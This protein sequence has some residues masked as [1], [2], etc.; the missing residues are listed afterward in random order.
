MIYYACS[1]VPLEIL[2][3]SGLSFMKIERA[4]YSEDP[5]VHRNLCGYCKATFEAVKDMNSDDLF[6]A[7]DSCDAMRRIND[8][9]Q[10]Y[11][12]AQILQLRLPWKR[13]DAS[14]IFYRNQLEGLVDM[15]SL[16]RGKTITIRELKEGIKSFNDLKKHLWSLHNK[17]IAYTEI[18]KAIDLANSGQKYQPLDKKV[19]KN[20]PRLAVAG[21]LMKDEEFLKMVGSIGAEIVFNETCAGMRGFTGESFPTA[22]PIDEIATRLI[23]RRIPCGRFI[24]GSDTSILRKIFQSLKVDGVLRLNQ[25]FCD[26]F[27]DY[28][29]PEELPSLSLEIDYPLASLGQL[30]TRIGAFVE[31]IKKGISRVSVSKTAGRY[32][33]GVDSGS[34]TTN[35]VITNDKGEILLWKIAPTGINGS[36]TAS[37][38][39]KEAQREMNF[40]DDDIAYCVATGYGRSIVDFANETITEITCHARGAKRFFPEAK[41]IIDIGGQD[42]KAI[43]LDEKGNVVDFSMN[44]KCAA[45]TGRFLEVMARV[46][47]KDLDAMADAAEKARKNLSISSM[48]TVFAES[49]VVSLI[50]K[51]ESIDD[52]SAG[53]FR[54]IS[55][56]IAAMYKRVKGEPPVVFTGGVARNSGIVKALQEELGINFLIP[57]VPDIVGAYGAAIMAME[58]VIR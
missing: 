32:F 42:S 41:C 10:S 58:K 37:K 53:L 15:L 46:L 8:L 47:E 35:L 29:L 7:V 25:K 54:S 50:G 22:D 13:D 23:Q 34:T 43:R 56:R 14:R 12:K 48:C 3:A 40:S 6:I 49:E 2:F 57:D 45:G 36:A 28:P 51:G 31:R 5:L 52:I 9:A 11:S 27:D 16:V 1:Y 19:A 24:D 38:L 18:Q 33:I 30:S 26:F 21:G 17:G 55:K 39:L 4:D 20:G 44:D